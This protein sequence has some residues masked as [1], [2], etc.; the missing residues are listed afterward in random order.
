M[1]R[2]FTRPYPRS[3]R[4]KTRVTGYGPAMIE[5]LA[6]GFGLIEGPRPD[7]E[8]NLFFSDVTRGGVH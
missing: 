2:P 6:W 4:L 7:A 3:P 1:V 5:M 8:G